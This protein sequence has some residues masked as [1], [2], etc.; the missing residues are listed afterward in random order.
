MNPV[1]YLVMSWPVMGT[2]TLRSYSLEQAAC[3]AF[4][5]ARDNAR[6]KRPMGYDMPPRIYSV[7]VK[8]KTCV[9]VSDPEWIQCLVEN[10]GSLDLKQGSCQAKQEFTFSTDK[11]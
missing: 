11:P 3:N 6:I 8:H 5:V 7:E 9:A 1:F 10:G 2:P 4:A